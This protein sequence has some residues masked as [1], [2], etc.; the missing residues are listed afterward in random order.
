MIYLM[1]GHAEANT[2]G[3][4][5]FV[6]N[7]RV[8]HCRPRVTISGLACAQMMDGVFI[9]RVAGGTKVRGLARWS[10]RV[11]WPARPDICS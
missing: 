8:I 9:W 10:A 11:N 6:S 2:E 4:T 1:S 5:K 3:S 7:M